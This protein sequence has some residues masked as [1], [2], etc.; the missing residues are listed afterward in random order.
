MLS[1]RSLASI[2][3]AERRALFQRAV[4]ENVTMDEARRRIAAERW[5]AADARLAHRKQP[6]AIDRASVGQRHHDIGDEGGQLAWWQ[7]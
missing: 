1:P 2:G 5:A 7:R 3:T 4:R 6:C